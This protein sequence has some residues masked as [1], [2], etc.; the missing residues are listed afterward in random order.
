MDLAAERSGFRDGEGAG[1]RRGVNEAGIQGRGDTGVPAISGADKEGCLMRR[2]GCGG[3]GCWEVSGKKNAV[4]LGEVGGRE[5]GQQVPG[6][7]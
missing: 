1:P 3:L 2:D 6:W 7:K 5:D 4:V